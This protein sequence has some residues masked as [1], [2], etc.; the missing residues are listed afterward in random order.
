MQ[1]PVQMEMGR[2]IRGIIDRYSQAMMVPELAVET[3]PYCRRRVTVVPAS[4]F[5]LRVVASP[6]VKV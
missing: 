2:Y 1:I 4:A 3:A 6:A 5:Q